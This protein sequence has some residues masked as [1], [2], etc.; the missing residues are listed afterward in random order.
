MADKIKVNLPSGKTVN[1]PG[2][3]K[4]DAQGT[5]EYIYSK[6]KDVPDFSD[7]AGY[8]ADKYNLG[9]PED[10]WVGQ[11]IGGTGGALAGAAKGAAIG[12]A[13]G[14]I[15]TVAGGIIGGGIGGFLGGGIGEVAEGAIRQGDV[16]TNVTGAAAT[17]GLFGLIPGVG[18]L[19]TKGGRAALAGATDTT[20]KFLRHPIKTL[21]GR[22]AGGIDQG[23]SLLAQTAAPGLGQASGFLGKKIA[24]K[25][26]KISDD[27]IVRST[28]KSINNLKKG[29]EKSKDLPNDLKT[30]LTDKL[31]KLK[32]N[33]N[34]AMLETAQAITDDIVKHYAKVDGIKKTSVLGGKANKAKLK[35]IYDE[36][37]TKVHNAIQGGQ[38]DQKVIEDIFK[39]ATATEI[40]LLGTRSLGQVHSGAE[41][42]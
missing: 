30:K 24:P 2:I 4:D 17:E 18:G 38:W 42:P 7:D 13:L 32:P 14:P 11:T 40:G 36:V 31:N 21:T 28:S 37:E 25:G 15:G 9:T 8:I 29:V 23:A 16:N 22:G 19:A 39:G 10:S 33:D 6:I 12:S 26:L 34:Q 1:I 41:G 3:Y 5:A 35:E 20:S 27:A